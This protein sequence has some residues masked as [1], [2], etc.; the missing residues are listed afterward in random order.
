[1]TVCATIDSNILVYAALEGDSEKGIVATETLALQSGRGVLAVQAMLEFVAV[2]RRRKPVLLP[3]AIIQVEAWRATYVPASTT[4]SIVSAAL[5]LVMNHQFQIWDAVIWMAARSVGATVML[6]EDLQH[7]FSFDGMRVV[8]PFV[9][10]A[11]ER[12]SLLG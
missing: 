10:T 6:S 1:M 2:V 12:E 9:L 7:D 3:T 8:N 11:Q 4:P 5:E